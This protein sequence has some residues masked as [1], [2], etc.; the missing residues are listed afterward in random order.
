A[1]RGGEGVAEAGESIAHD[2]EMFESAMDDDLNVSKAMAAIFG[3]VN[4]LN[5]LVEQERL[6]GPEASKALDFLKRINGVFQILDLEEQ[7]PVERNVTELVRRRDQ[8][9]ARKDW[10]EADRIRCELAD[11]GIRL[12]DTPKG[13][14]CVR[15]EKD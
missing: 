10:I 2:M 3:M 15:E 6:E 9:R 7:T 13:T 11:M 4:R 8:A 5:P 12:M 14:I 1:E